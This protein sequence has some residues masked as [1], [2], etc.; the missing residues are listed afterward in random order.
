[1]QVLKL[2]I[3]TSWQNQVN[4]RPLGQE[5]PWHKG[6]QGS[7]LY[8]VTQPTTHSEAWELDDVLFALSDLLLC[9]LAATLRAKLWVWA[10]M[11][12]FGPIMAWLNSAHSSYHWCNVEAD[13]TGT[14]RTVI[15]SSVQEQP[16]SVSFSRGC[17]AQ[18]PTE[19]KFPQATDNIQSALCLLSVWILSIPHRHNQS[20]ERRF[21]LNGFRDWSIQEFKSCFLVF[22][23]MRMVE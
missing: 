3:L 11:E 2:W 21:S 15:K 19:K 16:Q 14:N 9:Y 6:C 13:S 10:E 23:G 20:E 4:Y 17:R 22:T 8:H 7:S 18:R 5:T 1:M 12:S